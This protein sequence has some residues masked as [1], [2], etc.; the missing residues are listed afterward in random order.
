MMLMQDYIMR[1]CKCGMRID[2]AYTVVND[3]FRELDFDGLA[4][5]ISQQETIRSIIDQ[6][7]D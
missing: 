6:Y 5:Y 2:D 7:V 4:E 1:L 3:F